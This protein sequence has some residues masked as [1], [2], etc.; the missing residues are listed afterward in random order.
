MRIGAFADGEVV[1]PA[2]FAI[3]RTDGGAI[4]MPPS[5]RTS[6]PGAM[7]DVQ[8]LISTPLRPVEIVVDANRMDSPPSASAAAARVSLPAPRRTRCRRR[9]A[10]LVSASLDPDAA[11]PRRSGCRCW[12]GH[13]TSCS[14]SI[15]NRVFLTVYCRRASGLVAL[16]V[17]SRRRGKTSHPARRGICQREVRTEG[18]S[19]HW[20]RTSTALKVT[21]S[22]STRGQASGLDLGLE[23][24][25]RPR[26]SLY[27]VQLYEPPPPASA[28][29]PP[30]WPPV[31]SRRT[32]RRATGHGDPVGVGETGGRRKKTKGA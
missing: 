14:R 23:K 28:S 6:M 10:L 1:E 29:S 12:L 16:L 21:G 19:G 5:P 24:V 4:T 11:C 2:V 25:P 15:R 26:P 32:V 17:V 13:L 31:A 22:T 7:L 30:P 9:R 18:L 27:A 8:F 3:P 20:P